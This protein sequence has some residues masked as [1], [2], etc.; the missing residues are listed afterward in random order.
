MNKNVHA[1]RRQRLQKRLQQEACDG[2][3]IST[4]ANVRYLSGFANNE[5]M[6]AFLLITPRD[7]VLITDYR[8]AEQAQSDCA[9][10]IVHVRDRKKES[11]AQA[12]ARWSGELSIAQLAIETDGLSYATISDWQQSLNGVS[13]RAGDGWI[14]HLRR[15]KDDDEIDA[16]RAAAQ[17]GDR[18]FEHWL[19][20]VHAG[21]S[22]RELAVEL[23]YLLMKSGSEGVAFPTILVSGARTAMP[24]GTPS[25]K[26]I[27]PGD[28]VTVD[29]GAVVNG[30]RSDMTRSFVVGKASAEQR[31]LYATVL[32]A[33]EVGIAA[34]KA[35][36]AGYEPYQQVRAVLNNSDYARF[37]GEGLGHCVGLSLHERP[38][39]DQNCDEILQENYVLT[40]EPGIYIPGIGG[41]RIEDDLRVTTH[42]AEVLT[43]SPKQLL[44]L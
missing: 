23:E 3:L 25:D 4:L 33:Q 36:V 1:L 19:T 32:Q 27:A 10:L 12:L 44:E 22:E 5:A 21:K 35:G 31:A 40:I 38:F 41:V 42:G 14:E 11:L 30:Y 16:I 15:I 43:R 6:V 7:N 18:C 39:L 13:L 9:G 2:M 37:A 20:L 8:F 34:V 17:I 26:I 28:W 29:F 24:H